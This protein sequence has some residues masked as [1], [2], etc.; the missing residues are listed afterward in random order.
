M[1][2]KNAG[3]LI[4]GIG[5]VILVVFALAD[6]IGIGQTTDK[7]GYIQIIGVVVGALIFMAGVALYRRQEKV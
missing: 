7:I 1:S 4:A 5:L 6:L 3:A 2:S